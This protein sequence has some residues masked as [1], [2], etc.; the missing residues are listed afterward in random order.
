MDGTITNFKAK[1]DGG[2]FVI[3]TSDLINGN[4]EVSIGLALSRFWADP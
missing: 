4:F 2:A 1:V 3:V